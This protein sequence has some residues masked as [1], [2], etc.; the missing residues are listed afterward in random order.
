[1][2]ADSKANNAYHELRRQILTNQ[3]S[4]ETRL[5]EDSWAV[6]LDVSRIAVREALTRLLGEGLVAL[7][8]KGGYYVTGMTPEDVY[9]IRELREVLELAAVRLAAQRITEDQLKR[10][11]DI[12]D[13]FSSF[14]QKGYVAGACEADIKFHETLL[15]ASGNQR[16]SKAYHFAQIPLFH[17]KLGKTR[18]YLEDY[19]LTDKEHRLLVEALR[20]RDVA[21][22]EQT[23]RT[24]FKRG[25]AAVLD[26]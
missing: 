26:M 15:A 9:Q 6:R 7:G 24:H 1:M 5:K 4:P 21:L 12:C 22:A 8:E 25:E 16:L 10:M 19:D 17:Q 13:D 2:K 14:V 11:Q 23:L 20:K 18:A 3:L